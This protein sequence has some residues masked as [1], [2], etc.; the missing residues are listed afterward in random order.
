MAWAD[1]NLGRLA[2]A[3]VGQHRTPMSPIF[4]NLTGRT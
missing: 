4:A 2:H 1:R 3:A